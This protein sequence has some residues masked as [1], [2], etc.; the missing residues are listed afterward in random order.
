MALYF[1][2]AHPQALLDSFEARVRQSEP[3]GRI[4]AWKKG[5]DGTLYTHSAAEWTEKAWLKPRVDADRLTF[6]ILRPEDRYVSVKA[7]AFFYGQLIET[8]TSQLDLTFDSVLVTP[9]C[10]DGDIW[11]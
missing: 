11:A 9:R 10:T 3:R 1:T 2:T 5:E 8:F 6:N 4:V 7:Y